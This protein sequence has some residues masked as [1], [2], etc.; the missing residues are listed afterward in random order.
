MAG[1]GWF[2]DQDHRVFNYKPIYYDEE[3][4]KRKQMFGD[5]DGSKDKEAKEK[6]YTP[7]V[8]LHG[9]FR[10]GNF[11]KRRSA[12]KAQSIIGIIGL[13]LF[14]VVLIFITKFYSLL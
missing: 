10:N 4:E 8:Y 11:E 5:V 3:K 12:N 6:G 7:G 14:A 1:F 13:A 2:G 9:A